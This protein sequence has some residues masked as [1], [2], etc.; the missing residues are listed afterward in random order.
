MGVFIDKVSVYC[1]TDD[2]DSKVVQELDTVIPIN[3]DEGGASWLEDV[4]DSISGW[5]I[6]MQEN[7]V[8][9]VRCLACSKRHWASVAMLSEERGE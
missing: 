7:G 1:D 3:L 5:D 2:C 9:F 6:E 8:H 4:C